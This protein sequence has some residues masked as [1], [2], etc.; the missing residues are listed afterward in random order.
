M[1]WHELIWYFMQCC[2]MEWYGIVQ[3]DVVWY[4]MKWYNMTSNP[5][6]HVVCCFITMLWCGTV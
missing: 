4:G 1:V 6:S 5:S 3:Y 2:R